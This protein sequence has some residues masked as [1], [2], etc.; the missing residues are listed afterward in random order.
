MISPS[1]VSPPDQHS[2]TRLKLKL[3]NPKPTQN[4]K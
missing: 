4:D 3:T 2:F 1:L